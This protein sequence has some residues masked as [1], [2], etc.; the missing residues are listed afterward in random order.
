MN[1]ERF[2]EMA[3]RLERVDTMRQSGGTHEEGYGDDVENGLAQSK[4]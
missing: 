4:E 2:R 3:E 1:G